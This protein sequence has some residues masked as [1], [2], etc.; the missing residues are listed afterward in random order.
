[1]KWP[2]KRC[3]VQES[4]QQSRGEWI[5]KKGTCV[6]T[7]PNCHYWS[8][9][10]AHYAPTWIPEPIHRHNM[11]AEIGWRLTSGCSSPAKCPLIML[12]SHMPNWVLLLFWAYM[13]LDNT[14]CSNNSDEVNLKHWAQQRLKVEQKCILWPIVYK[15]F[16]AA[17][18][19]G[20]EGDCG[21]V[22]CGS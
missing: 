22:I 1:M 12:H 9:V 2:K 6:T 7:K 3:A 14:K 10:V 17:A 5:R 8:C 4:N 16:F 21:H 20:L 18:I 19:E 15:Y 11:W 13:C